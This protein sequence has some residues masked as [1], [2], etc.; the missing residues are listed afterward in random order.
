MRKVYYP[1]HVAEGVGF[2]SDEWSRVSLDQA[3]QG[4][5]KDCRRPIFLR[6]LPRSGKILEAGCGPAYYVK[7]YRSLGYDMYGVDSD[8]SA[9]KKALS[10]DPH[11]PLYVADVSRLPFPDGAFSA[12]YSGGVIE[13]AEDGPQ[14]VL[15]EAYRIL[16]PDGILVISV[17]VLNVK[18]SLE[19]LAVFSAGRRTWRM[20][21]GAILGRIE[22]PY[23]Y[24]QRHVYTIETPPDGHHFH[25]YVHSKAEVQRQLE[26]A[27]FY[28]VFSRGISIQWGLLDFPAVQRWHRCVTSSGNGERSS[29]TAASSLPARR[30]WWRRAASPLVETLVKEDY[31]VWPAAPLLWCLH[32]WFSHSVL[33]VCRKRPSG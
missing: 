23:R 6:F 22:V 16:R 29:G 27:G 2:W 1:H 17:P 9:I 33:F 5:A 12:Y 14:E 8:A 32:Q 11:L 20:A 28:P 3:L 13:H 19:D 7:Y 4:C 24:T 10:Y 15:R 21:K 18:R 31:S 30:P 26:L 25:L